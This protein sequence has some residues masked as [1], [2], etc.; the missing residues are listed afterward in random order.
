MGKYSKSGLLK[1]HNF[2]TIEIQSKIKDYSIDEVKE[3]KKLKANLIVIDRLGVTK[4]F[5]EEIKNNFKKIIIDDSSIQRKLFDIS[6]NPHPE[7]T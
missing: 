1:N 7:C 3:L 4:N 5:Y 6:L 2:K